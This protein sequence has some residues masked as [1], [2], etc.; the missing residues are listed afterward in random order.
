MANY[1]SPGVYVEEISLLPPSI[2]EVESA[3]P[4]FIG[5]TEKATL[6][7]AGDL[8]DVPTPITSLADF[9]QYFGGPPTEVATNVTL[10][11]DELKTGTQ[12]TG[13]KTTI[14]V[15]TA[16]TSDHILYYAL[17]HF[18]TNGG[19]RCYIVSIGGYTGTVAQADLERGLDIIANEDTPTMLV[20]PE[21][22][23]LAAQ[24]AYEAVNQK[25]IN[26]AATLKDR[27]AIMDTYLTTVP[28]TSSSVNADVATAIGTI[29]V[30][31]SIRRYGAVYYP[32]LE[33]SYSYNFDFDALTIGTHTINGAAPTVPADDKTGVALS[34][35]K[36]TA[37]SMYNAI[38]AEYGK[39]HIVLPPSAA[40]A[41]VYSRVDRERGFWKAPANVGLMDVVK[42]RVSVS[43]SEH[44]LLN[45][46][47][48]TGKS[49]NAILNMPGYGTVVM[50]GRT[51]DGNDNEWRYIN[52]RRFFSVVEE[53]IKKSSNWAI[54]E[55]N[56][57]PTWVKVK[58]MIENY[59]YLKWRDGAL[60][61]ATPEQAFFVNI[62]LGST[63]TSVDILEGR[64]IVEIG[65]AVARP[66]EFIILKFEQMM[67]TS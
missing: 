29:P 59:L 34:V 20:V 43:R 14:T 4:A 40:M 12:T 50:G 27:F 24:A 30:D 21:A 45:V 37:S 35:L 47:S 3:V 15:N 7:V 23:N 2:A 28:K 38:A 31:G 9:K 46:N 19:G 51:L 57:S 22:I 53:S 8:T 39:Y 17:R 41:G 1:R 26:Q 5:Y 67:Q 44:D 58:A 11:V 18:F 16:N 10:A 61:G 42:P 25:M 36:N 56:T 60:A 33:T 13:F 65:M 48:D 6:L 64:M 32:Y 66:A 49:V 55:P 52:V 62:G 54:F 63:M